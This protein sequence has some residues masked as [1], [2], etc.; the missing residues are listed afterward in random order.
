M[1]VLSH[2]LCCSCQ[3]H[4]ICLLVYGFAFCSSSQ[5]SIQRIWDDCLVNWNLLLTVLAYDYCR[6]KNSNMF[7]D[8]KALLIEKVYV[9]NVLGNFSLLYKFLDLLSWVNN[10]LVIFTLEYWGC[11]NSVFV[12]LPCNY[13][14]VLEHVSCC[15]QVI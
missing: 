12:M 3:S 7:K 8:L 1:N 15:F 14:L 2:L 11:D 5:S 9:V 6:S 4:G 10:C 13:K